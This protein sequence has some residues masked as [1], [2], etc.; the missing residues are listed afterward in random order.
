MQGQGPTN[1]P[2]TDHLR[3]EL[4]PVVILMMDDDRGT[5][6]LLGVRIDW[7]KRR[8]QDLLDIVTSS[9]DMKDNKE[10]SSPPT[11]PK[12]EQK[13]PV[14]SPLS[15]GS[16]TRPPDDTCTAKDLIEDNDMMSTSSS[17]WD[18]PME[19]NIDSNARVQYDGII[20]CRHEDYD[21]ESI[22]EGMLLINCLGLRRYSVVPREILV[23]KPADMSVDEASEHADELLKKLL[24][25]DMLSCDNTTLTLSSLAS[26]RIVESHTLLLDEDRPPDAAI[27]LF[28][29]PFE[30]C[31][32]KDSGHQK[33]PSSDA[34]ETGST[35]I[36]EDDAITHASGLLDIYPCSNAVDDEG[37]NS[38]NVLLKKNWETHLGDFYAVTTPSETPSGRQGLLAGT[39]GTV[40]LPASCKPRAGASKFSLKSLASI[41]R[42]AKKQVNDAV[43][44]AEKLNYLRGKTTKHG[45]K[46]SKVV[47]ETDRELMREIVNATKSEDEKTSASVASNEYATGET[48]R[49]LSHR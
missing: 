13:I 18:P 47:E 1:T 29:P 37:P 25:V 31:T 34:D 19:I 10:A 6:D 9:K 14:V 38:P 17:I 43:I 20:Q 16:A 39:P 40:Q 12:K 23:A 15:C 11:K 44:D 7:Q 46:Y 49:E 5:F 4:V 35:L 30:V 2:P 22:V 26:G 3:H 24:R 33:G 36:T 45:T 42:G 32:R 21:D 8:V 48:T 27:L 41:A 28:S